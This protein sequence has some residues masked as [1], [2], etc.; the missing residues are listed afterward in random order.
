MKIKKFF[1][2]LLAMTFCM[3]V[4]SVNAYAYVDE[5]AAAE[6]QPVQ[7][8][9]VPEKTPEPESAEE[10]MEALTPDGNLTIVDDNGSPTGAGKQFIT[11]VSKD[12]NYFYLI[13]DRD[14]EGE[15]T[16]HFLNQVDE[17][18]LMALTEDGEK[19]ETPIVCTCTEKCQ[20][21]A[22]NTACPVCVKNL[23]ECV[24]TEQKAA[25]PTEPENPEPKKKSNTGAIL[26]VLLI[27]AAGGGAAVY[28]LVLKPKQGKKVPADLDDFDLE[29]EEEYLTEDEETEEKNE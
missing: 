15:Q 29:D 27:L 11:L 4:F 16:V 10:P 7:E 1:A 25:E 26:A 2:L 3:G 28:F 24:G 23:S 8:E 22:V 17:A 19:A 12:G 21:G 14:D 9:P 18:D 13:I 5:S 20:A 6:S